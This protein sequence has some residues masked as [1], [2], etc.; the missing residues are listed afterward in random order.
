M[1]NLQV[2]F[3]FIFFLAVSTSSTAQQALWSSQ[4]ITSPKVNT[5]KSVTFSLLAPNASKVEL[6]GD[7]ITTQKIDTPNGEMEIP[8]SI[9]MQKNEKGIW[10]YTTD[11][12]SSELYIYNFML[13]GVK[14][15]DPS[16]VYAVRD[17][18]SMMNLFLIDGGV[19]DL[20]K[21]NNVPHG[22]IT[23]EWYQSSTL[24]MS[25]RITVYTPPAYDGTNNNKKY[26]VLYLLHGMGGDEQAWEE[27]GR[28]TQI[29]DNLIALGKA[30]P[31][32]VVMPNGNVS[33]NAAPGYSEKGYYTPQMYLPS[34]MDGQ[35]EMSFPDIVKFVDTHY[36]TIQRKEGR[37]ITGLS[38]GG[39][40]SLH[41]SKQYPDM[42]DY[43]G[44]FSAAID[45]RSQEKDISTFSIYDNM[46]EKLKTQFQK[47]PK[48]YWIGIGKT[49]FLF[50]ENI[51]FRKRLDQL[52]AKYIYEETEG[53]HIWK[54]WR[55]YLSD[56]VPLLF[57]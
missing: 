1:R 57:K 22:A 2:I 50:E 25:R 41:I 40:H 8:G 24:N 19:G 29:L 23:K 39:F 14:I 10:S 6:V 17:I 11:V 49:D 28:A 38:M 26:P 55:I 43:V 42:F 31:M 4:N 37:A 21:V 56:F 27:L 54:N 33:Q 51:K 53:G 15:T 44:L 12:L 16:N 47:A 30:T 35:M 7:F 3:V 13:D 9:L 36:R 32:I 20:Y 34:T 45:S 46:D 52:G 5:D 18:S 48:L